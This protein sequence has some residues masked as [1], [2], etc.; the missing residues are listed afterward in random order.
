MR[1]E[2]LPPVLFRRGAQERR[3]ASRKTRQIFNL[4]RIYHRQSTPWS[5]SV[6]KL[7]IIWNKQHK[8]WTT[9]AIIEEPSCFRPPSFD[10]R[11]PKVW[12]CTPA[13]T[14]TSALFQLRR[15]PELCFAAST[16]T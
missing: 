16:S 11:P 15:T 4:L 10:R 2:A 3:K 5:F 13:S 8:F 9:S 7:L 14:D 6:H 12:G 1:R